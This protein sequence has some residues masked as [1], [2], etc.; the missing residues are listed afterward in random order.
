MSDSR[1]VR[2]ELADD[3][4]VAL[5]TV[6]GAIMLIS[7]IATSGYWMAS[8]SLHA[9]EKLNYGTKAFQVASSGMDRELASFSTSNF[10]TGQTNY[11]RSGSTP[12]GTYQLTVGQDA[13]VPFMYTM[14]SVGR[15]RDESATV[16]QTFFY[17]DLWGMS[18][19]AGSNP[20]GPVGSGASWNGNS[21]IRGPLYVKG[22]VF[23]NSN[24][25]LYYGPMF[26][27]DGSASFQ[28]GVEFIPYP[29]SKYNI[30]S[31]GPVAG[32]TSACKV[33]TSCPT[34]DLPWIDPNYFSLMEDKAELQSY[35]NKLGVLDTTNSEDVDVSPGQLPATYTSPKAPNASSYY[36]VINGDLVITAATPSFGKKDGPGVVRDDLVFDSATDTLYVNG[37][38]FV[39]GNVTI[40]SGVRG[41]IGN[42]IIV[43]TGDITVS[44]GNGFSF[45][46]MTDNGDGIAND[47]SVENCVALAAKNNVYI[48]GCTVEAVI[49]TNQTLHLAKNGSTP[50]EFE[51]AVHANNI[52]S[53]TPANEI[54][55][56]VN[57]GNAFLPDGMPGSASDP[58][59]A[60]YSSQ[61]MVIPGTWIRR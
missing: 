8:Q 13:N 11:S 3:S 55:M 31:T 18:V 35:D 40:G 6:I 28:G 53:D 24:A 22:D 32:A 42:G 23:M 52:S 33:Y 56:E 21:S 25:K 7:I 19:S 57:F 10:Q 58:R 5:V 15:A 37:T 4:G 50:A 54:E 60:E 41:Y 17:L 9:S 1:F 46:P 29:N 14:R 30:F 12:D 20:G 2:R 26:I 48:H 45:Q 34:L 44:T 27:S 49:F 43:S 38:V 16:E 61:G 39:N 36:K 51:G 59:G 47:L